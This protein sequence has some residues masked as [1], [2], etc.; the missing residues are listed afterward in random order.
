MEIN[1]SF[2]SPPHV[3]VVVVVDDDDVGLVSA[4]RASV[5]NITAMTSGAENAARHAEEEVS[6]AEQ[7]I[8]AFAIAR[9]ACATN[10]GDCWWQINPF[11][12]LVAAVV[13]WVI[14][15][16]TS[17][18]LSSDVQRCIAESAVS[19]LATMCGVARQSSVANA[20]GCT[21]DDDD[22]DGDDDDAY[23]FQKAVS[24][25]ATLKDFTH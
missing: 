5:C 13:D 22:N 25:S 20:A 21:A 10:S 11:A 7:S 3:V 9:Q 6:A 18:L 2:S 19:M 8:A 24:F 14:T 17:S 15:A 23:C 16:V 4:L 1:D 12:R